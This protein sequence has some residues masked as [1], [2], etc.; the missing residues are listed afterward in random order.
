MA[1]GVSADL[2]SNRECAQSD[3]AVCRGLDPSPRGLTV[4]AEFPGFVEISLRSL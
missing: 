4:V 1:E 3:R 2:P